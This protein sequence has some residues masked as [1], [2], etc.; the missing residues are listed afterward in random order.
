MF[1]T[2][3][4]RLQGPYWRV[5]CKPKEMAV[6]LID[7]DLDADAAGTMQRDESYVFIKLCNKIIEKY[8]YHVVISISISKSED[9]SKDN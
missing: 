6:S 5:L 9:K 2:S 3:A 8:V 4:V 7:A 1:L